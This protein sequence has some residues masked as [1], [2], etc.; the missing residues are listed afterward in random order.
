M[1]WR[2]SSTPRAFCDQSSI[3]RYRQIT[4]RRCIAAKRASIP[5]NHRCGRGQSNNAVTRCAM[6]AILRRHHRAKSIGVRGFGLMRGAARY[7]ADSR[8]GNHRFVHTMNLERPYVDCISS[9][10]CSPSLPC[11]SM[12]TPVSLL[13][14]PAMQASAPL[15]GRHLVAITS[16]TKRVFDSFARL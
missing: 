11:A 2:H 7:C 3:G 13:R 4:V 12:S 9:S 15:R 6:M 1:Q 16:V 14:W 10:R 5:S 8:R